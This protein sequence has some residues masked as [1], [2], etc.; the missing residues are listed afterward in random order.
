MS[1]RMIGICLTVLFLGIAALSGAFES[2]V[3]AGGGVAGPSS[4]DG[5]RPGFKGIAQFRNEAQFYGSPRYGD[6]FERMAAK[7]A[8]V[9]NQGRATGSALLSLILILGGV[10]GAILLA[11]G[12][13]LKSGVG[14]LAT[15][16]AF[17]VIAFTLAFGLARVGNFSVS[18]VKERATSSSAVARQ[19]P[20]T[21]EF[22]A[23]FEIGGSGVTQIGGTVIDTAGNLYVTG[24]FQNAVYFNTTP[25]PTR[26]KATQ[27]YDFFVAKFSPNRKCLWARMANGS[28]SIGQG[29]SLEGGLAI[30]VDTIGN[31]YVGGGFVSQVSF[32]NEAGQEVATL[33][34]SGDGVNTES[35]LVKYS[36]DGTLLWA[37]GGNTGSPQSTDSLNSGINGIIDIVL[38]QQG[39]PYVCGTSAG[40]QFLGNPVQ[41]STGVGVVIAR[42]N[43]Q[44][45]EPVWTTSVSGTDH[46]GI[47]GLTIDRADN[48]YA[49]GNFV[50]GPVTFPTQ[51]GPTSFTNTD[52]LGE[53][54]YIAKYTTDGQCR[55]ARQI[56]GAVIGFDIAAT[57]TGEF[58]VAGGY[59][60]RADF[61]N[62]SLESSA[63]GASGFLAK[64]SAEGTLLLVREFG[65]TRY[66]RASRVMTDTA[67]TVYVIGMLVGEADFGTEGPA[68]IS[69]VSPNAG[70]FVAAYNAAGVFQF[71]KQVTGTNNLSLNLIG[72]NVNTSLLVE[73]INATIHPIT[74]QL[75]MSG[76]FSGRLP[77]G[78]FITLESDD[79][80]FDGD[81][82]E[83]S[84]DFDGDGEDDD[85]ED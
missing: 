66:T 9:E 59:L 3:N 68:P 69:L 61:G 51:P 25:L 49:V 20:A 54:T 11:G 14:I 63:T 12:L 2:T 32:K 29:L 7:N 50:G 8:R 45:G 36:S 56:K 35:F 78:S 55:F 30:T 28:D 13:N 38:D 16:G 52:N 31:C 1:K 71:V 74:G 41:H 47:L 19:S 75:L 40:T 18:G 53:N 84:T 83:D 33:S 48:L 5:S 39:N 4:D 27:D 85:D 67:G 42:I 24:G 76:D 6:S 73:P 81:G 70:M 44:T 34:D 26:L 65:K 82:E 10:V 62:I 57:A 43:Q 22:D 80:D 46:I 23:S 17:S 79:Q 37:R 58:Y 15:K 72:R 60:T 21:P 77:L 64:Y